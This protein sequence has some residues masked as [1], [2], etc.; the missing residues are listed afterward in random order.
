M[1]KR[2]LKR[3]EKGL[4]GMPLKLLI[5]SV[6]LAIAIPAVYNSVE[7]YDTK[8][9]LKNLKSEIQFIG[10]KA[11][12]VFIHGN[13]NSEV[14]EVDFSDGIFEKIN[15]VK[16]CCEPDYVIRWE[17]MDY[18]GQYSIPKKIPLYNESGEI[19]LLKG[20]HKLRMTCKYGNPS[21]IDGSRSYFD[22]DSQ[23]LEIEVLR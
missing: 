2:S 4:E 6:V 14:I 16:L 19:G 22:Q 1:L 13:G 17:T 3:D 10:E 23:Y 15:I 12:Q 9:T 20:S 11:E 21:N 18:N 7:Y 8:G 5:I